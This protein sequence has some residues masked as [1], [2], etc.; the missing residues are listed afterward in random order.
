[1]R[2]DD[3][4]DLTLLAEAARA[5]GDIARRHFGSGPETWQKGGGQGPVTEADL[6]IDAMLR[7][8]LLAARPS[9]GW[10]SEETADGPERLACAR[11]FVV[12]PIDGTRAFLEGSLHFS[13]SLAVVEEGVP[14][15]AAVYLPMRDEMFLAVRGGGATLNGAAISVT[16]RAALEGATVLGTKSHFRDA[17]WRGGRPPVDQRFMSSLAYRLAL[18]GQGRFDAMI[19]LRDA[20]EWDIAAGALI[21]TEAGGGVADRRGRPLAFNTPRPLLDGV[22][23]GAPGIAGALLARLV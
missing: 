19:T 8:D 1:M 9:Y 10:L 7:R 17:L 13:H 21:V 12:D 5:A 16:G 6:E 23:A 11:V 18:V 22:I 20:W 15:A 14:V 4:A 3:A 2:A